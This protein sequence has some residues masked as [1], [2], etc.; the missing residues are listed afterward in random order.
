MVPV[1]RRAGAD[2]ERVRRRGN[3]ALDAVP[4]GQRRLQRAPLSRELIGVLNRAD[5]EARDG[6]DEYVSTEHLRSLAS[7]PHADVGASRDQIAEAVEGVRGPHRVTDQN[8]EDKYQASRSSAATSPTPPSTASRPGDRPRRR[9]PAVI[10][11]LSRRTKNNPVLIGEPGVGKT[12]VEGLAAA[13]R[14]RR[15][16]RVPARSA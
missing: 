15:R 5:E 14:L 13:D 4:T 11:V 8:P 9:G 2:P 16:A 12:V 1:P 3:E 7:E 10:Q 6:R